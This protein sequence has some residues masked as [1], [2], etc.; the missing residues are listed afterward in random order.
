MFPGLEAPGGGPADQR[1]FAFNQARLY[2][3]A[4][5]IR[6]SMVSECPRPGNSLSSVTAGDCRYALSVLFTNHGWNGVVLLARD[7]Q[8]GAAVGR[9]QR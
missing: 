3:R 5:A 6:L 7:E 1:P 8:E 2:W 9:W 4:R